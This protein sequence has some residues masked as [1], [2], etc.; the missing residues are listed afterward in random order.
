MTRSY[1]ITGM[2]CAACSAAVERAVKRLNNID[3]ASVNLATEHLSVRAETIDD[4]AILTAVAKAGFHAEVIVDSVSQAVRDREERQ[5]LIRVKQRRSAVA[6][7]F[8]VLLFYVA[9]SPMLHL[10]CPVSPEKNAVVFALT[11]MALLLPILIAGRD[12]YF[13]GFP[14]LVRLH[15]NMDSLVAIGTLSSVLFSLYSFLELLS[16]DTQAVHRMYWESAGVVIA[17]VML[18]KLFEARSKR[19]TGD[20]VDRMMRLAPDTATILDPAGNARVIPVSELIRGD[21]VLV[22]PGER[23]PADGTVL[24]GSTDVNESMLS[25]ES[26]PVDKGV[27]SRVVCGSINGSGAFSFRA[28]RVGTETTLSAMI[29]LVEDAQGSKAPIS[30]LAD[31]IAGVFVPVV[32]GIALLSAVVWAIAGKDLPFVLTTFV[33]VLVIACPCALGLAT[34]TAIM[35]GTGAAAEQGILIKNGETLE[36]AGSIRAIAFDKTGTLTSGKPSVTDI[37]PVDTDESAFLSLFASGEAASE[38]PIGRA[39][40]QAAAMRGLSVSK[41]SD[42]RAV[43][44]F[45]AEATV[46]GK[47]LRMGSTAFLTD[48]AK[49]IPVSVLALANSGK[50]TVHLSVD[51]AYAG[52]VAVSD[53]I[54]PDAHGAVASLKARGIIPILLTGDNAETAR[55]IADEAGIETVCAEVTP[56]R[57]ASEIATLHDTNGTVAMVG[58]GIND[59]PALA[60]ADIGIAIGAGTDVALSSADIVLMR[61]ELSAVADAI[62][63]SR[64]TIR[65]IRQNLFWAFFYNCIGIPIAAGVLYAFGGPKLSP[66]VGAFAMSF[67]SVTVVSNALRLKP[68]IRKALAHGRVD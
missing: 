2:H 30:R 61:D 35:V 49:E 67:S 40:T 46:D 56:D 28:E 12:F 6:L 60:T 58:D 16:G 52:S 47:K 33:S 20:A 34:P 53:T 62:E 66:M 38:H 19:R 31:R 21:V 57:K 48:I 27:G 45:G 23:I 4:D 17:L 65:V 5:N 37:L 7:V 43:A 39:I 14:A 8:G 9:M 13:S 64:L 1:K 42:F 29:R 24:N 41:A 55:A 63:I 32:I 22:K 51:G 18:G 59:A 26:M 15:P 11:Q 54:K 25:G 50:T 10:P 3:A 68:L 36:T 44:G